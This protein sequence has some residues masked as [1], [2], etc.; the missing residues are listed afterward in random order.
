MMLTAQNLHYSYQVEE[1]ILDNV[2]LSLQPGEKKIIMGPSGCGKTTLLKILSGLIPSQQGTV[3]LNLSLSWKKSFIFQD[4]Q[5]V[6][7]LTVL[8]NIL[9]PMWCVLD[10]YPKDLEKKALSLIHEFGLSHKEYEYPKKLSGGQQQRVGIIRALINAPEIIFA[11]EPT[12][13]LDDKTTERTMEL[14][15]QILQEN[16]TSLL[17]VTHD[18]TL[19]K[20]V[21]AVSYMRY[22]QL[23]D[24]EVL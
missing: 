2:S 23:H 22:Q 19:T 17:M 6:S 8:E 13:Q 10:K 24:Q 7:Y 18:R 9:L 16:K 5:L 12:G 3:T 15:S 11:D 20:F 14:M 4:N 21:D 1:P